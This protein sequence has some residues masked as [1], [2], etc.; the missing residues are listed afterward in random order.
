MVSKNTK[1]QS[2]SFIIR[3]MQ[4]KIHSE[5]PPRTQRKGHN[6]QYYNIKC[7]RRQRHTRNLIHFWSECK[8]RQPPVKH[9]SVP[10]VTK[11]KLTT[12][13]QNSTPRSL[14][15]RNKIIQPHIELSVN[16]HSTTAYPGPKLKKPKCPSTG[17]EQQNV[18]HLY[19]VMLLHN[20]LEHS[21]T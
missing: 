14:S 21:V 4:I 2:I 19:K 18:V 11:H 12:F 1:R 13:F 20:K 6:Q 10:Q 7:Q 8:L 17:H 3:E 16:V 15:K 9:L 5:V